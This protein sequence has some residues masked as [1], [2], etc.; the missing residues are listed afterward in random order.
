[1]P[2]LTCP[3]DGSEMQEVSREGVLIDIC[4]QCQ[5]VWLD[6]GELDKLVELLF[7][8]DDASVRDQEPLR[9]RPSLSDF[10]G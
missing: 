8:L 9:K 4:P 7:V 6:R 2:L 5:G 3:N 10:F 1:M